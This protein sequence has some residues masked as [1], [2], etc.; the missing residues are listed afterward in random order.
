MR[1]H[2]DLL[3]GFF[4]GAEVPSDSPRAGKFLTGPNQWPKA[5]ATSEFEEPLQ[6]YRANM[7]ELAQ[8]VLNLLALALPSPASTNIFDDFMSQPSANLRLLHYP[9]K[10]T[11]NPEQLGCECIPFGIYDGTDP[12]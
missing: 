7:V 2:A 11:P 12:F 3:Q 1:C 8:L 9:P 10:V 4:I 6:K 5:I